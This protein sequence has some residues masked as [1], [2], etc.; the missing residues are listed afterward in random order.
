[1]YRPPQ[2]KALPALST[3]LL[4]NTGAGRGTPCQP[5]RRSLTR[6][7]PRGG[8]RGGVQERGGGWWRGWGGGAVRRSPCGLTQSRSPPLGLGRNPSCWGR[9][10]CPLPLPLHLPLALAPGPAP[11]L[12]E[13]EGMR[14][15][16][17]GTPG[18]MVLRHRRPDVLPA[19]QHARPALA[20]HL[21]CDENGQ[22][23]DHHEDCNRK[24]GRHS[25]HSQ[26]RRALSP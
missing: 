23:G 24:R 16:G 6:G 3:L 26:P 18:R 20:R 9:P 5:R 21:L 15:A 4:S 25:Q 19:H 13:A 8:G 10:S 12:W 2:S 7:A 1:V 14:A 11:P 17:P 22:A